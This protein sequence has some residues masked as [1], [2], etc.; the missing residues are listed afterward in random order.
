MSTELSNISVYFQ[1]REGKARIQMQRRNSRVLVFNLSNYS[2][3]AAITRSTSMSTDM[4]EP[5]P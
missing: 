5:L 4:I 2:K 3:C 1:R